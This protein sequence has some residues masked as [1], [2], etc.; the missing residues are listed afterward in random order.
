MIRKLKFLQDY[1]CFAAG[2]AVDFRPGLNLLVGDQ[3][4]GKS[5][6]L[7]ILTKLSRGIESGS[8]AVAKLTLSPS[9]KS[10]AVLSLDLEKDNP[11]KQSAVRGMLDVSSHFMS[12]GETVNLLLS[13]MKKSSRKAPHVFILDEPD[14]AL[15]PRSIDA[16]AKMFIHCARNSQIIASAHNPWMIAAA[17]DVY[18]VE[19]R[20]WIPSSEFLD[21][22][23]NQP[24]KTKSPKR[25][26]RAN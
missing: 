19:H 25:K 9:V 18:S 20:R 10:I 14:M 12:H 7:N 3:G 24:N 2:F 22:Q 4:A 1:R 13:H 5:S 23:R 8:G 16:L 26:R 21:S 17:G 15:S 11:R 6:L